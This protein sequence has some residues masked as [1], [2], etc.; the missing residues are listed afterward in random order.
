MP[1]VPV[2]FR[3]LLFLIIFLPCSGCAYTYAVPVRDGHGTGFVYPVCYPFLVVNGAKTD[4][5]LVPNPRDQRAARF[6]AFLSKNNIEVKF[7]TCGPETI[8]SDMDSTGVAIELFKTLQ[9]AAKQGAFTSRAGGEPVGGEPGQNF[10]VFEFVF[11]DDG[12]FVGLKPLVRP[13]DF[14]RVHTSS[15][16][17]AASGR[18]DTAEQKRSSDKVGGD[19]AP[20]DGF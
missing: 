14:V 11:S 8:K 13:Q 10:Q 6:G 15:S 16:R 20:K 9:E 5:L 2:Y 17:T 18:R 3:K 19:I 4:L 7:A 12:A 1:E